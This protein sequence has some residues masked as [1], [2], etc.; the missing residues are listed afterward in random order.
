MVFALNKKL[1]F[2]TTFVVLLVYSAESQDIVS[3]EGYLEK[4]SV[5]YGKVLDYTAAIT[6]TSGKNTPQQGSL[7][8]KSPIYLRIDYSVPK[9][10]VLVIDGQKLIIYVPE[11][12]AVLEQAYRNRAPTDLLGMASK[13]GL[14][15]LRGNYGVAFLATPEPVPLDDGSKEMVVKLRLTP[16]S[17][18]A[19]FS[20]IILS[21]GADYMIRRMDGLYAG[22]VHMVMD[23]TNI[24]INQSIPDSRFKYDY[25]PYANVIEDFL[26]EAGG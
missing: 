10:Q 18:G 13:Q 19:P 1:I 12:D 2:L 5:E 24:K 16:K 3:A 20:E 22:G 21:V 8:Y 11:L 7:S 9:G 17:S 26:F 15:I 6:F 4:V 23:L 14:T 25:P